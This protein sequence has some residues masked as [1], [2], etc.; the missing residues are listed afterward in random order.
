ML[1]EAARDL[2]KM[3]TAVAR[4]VVARIRW[5]A[6]NLED[7]QPE[8][9]TGNLAGFYKLRAGDYRVV[10]EIVRAGSMM[11]VHLVGHRR[12]IYRR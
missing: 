12:E 8:A 5:L 6:E 9:L 4:R 3:D 11:I 7:L 10:Y 2:A 1:E